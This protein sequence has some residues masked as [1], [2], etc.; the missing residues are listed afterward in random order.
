MFGKQGSDL[1]ERFWMAAHDSGEDNDHNS[2]YK[3][4]YDRGQVSGPG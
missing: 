1:G 4:Y 3:N 2:G